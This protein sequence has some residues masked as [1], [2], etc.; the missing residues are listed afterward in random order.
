MVGSLKA[1][2]DKTPWQQEPWWKT[3]RLSFHGNGNHGGLTQDTRALQDKVPWQ[4]EL[5]GGNTQQTGTVAH[6]TVSMATCVKV[7][8]A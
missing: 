5:W 6:K 3:L 1:L 8:R 4:Q 2:Q 7:R